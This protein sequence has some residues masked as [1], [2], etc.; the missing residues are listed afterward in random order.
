MFATINQ[1]FSPADLKKFQQTFNI[2]LQNVT[3][4]EGLS[5]NN[6]DCH[7]VNRCVEGNLDIQ[8]IMAVARKMN[9]TFHYTDNFWT[10]FLVEL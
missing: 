7:D 8:Y 6:Y 10:E 5:D 9:C 1:S 4:I 2:P 3:N